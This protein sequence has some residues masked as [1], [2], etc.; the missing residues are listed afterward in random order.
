ME[1]TILTYNK[2]LYHYGILGQKW[3]VRRYQNKDGTLTEA[4]R[5]RLGNTV[6]FDD[7]GR[8]TSSQRK[9]MHEIHTNVAKDY[10]SM[11]SALNDTSGIT[12]S[13]VNI[14]ER[15]KKLKQEKFKSEMDLSNMSDDDIRQAVNRL[16]LEKQYK[17]LKSENV[18]SGKEHVSNVLATAGDI[19]A[20]GASIAGIAVA[21]HTIRS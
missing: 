4:G 9:A 11:K 5:R 13:S 18:T 21:I 15:F 8:I 2:E 20:I 6:T 17:T 14:N 10:G 19:L 12:K 7:E 1:V 16:N 3:G